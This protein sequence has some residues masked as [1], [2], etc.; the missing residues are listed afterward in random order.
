[1]SHQRLPTFHT[2]SSTPKLRLP[3]G[4]WDTHC[5]VF[6]PKERF[7]FAPTA[8]ID[9]ADAPKEKLFALHAML[10]I[11]RCV[12][13]Q[14]ALHGVD[15]RAV[16]DALQAKGGSYLGVA[17][18]PVTV[19]VVELRRLDRLGFRGVRFNFMRHLQQTASVE[20]VIGLGA[21]LAD[22][23]WHLQVHMESSLIEPMSAV[24]KLSPV[25]VVIDHIGRVDASLGVEQPRFQALLRLLQDDRFWVKVSG[26]DRITRAGPPYADAL[27]FARKLLAEFPDRV[28]WGTDW[29]HP[30]HA[31]PIP[32]DGM[33]VDIVAE[34]APSQ[35]LRH[36]L[37]V[38]NP[39]R[40]Y[41][42]GGSQ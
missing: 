5:H 20:D 15:N 16:E 35:G 14:S 24:L 30:H 3:A 10:G 34:M 8:A 17:L 27:P 31:G 1:M 6:G 13:V 36:K 18:L 2:G 33:L 42:R 21:R 26:C 38:D 39:Q 29:P 28:V 23:G 12:V 7:P 22:I 25:P 41:D 37:M 19:A 40:L 32:D 11:E 9:P 4:S